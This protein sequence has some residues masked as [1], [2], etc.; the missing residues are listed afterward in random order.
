MTE[1]NRI[2]FSMMNLSIAPMVL[3]FEA[4][5]RL[6]EQNFAQFSPDG[7][8]TCVIDQHHTGAKTP[9]P[10]VTPEDM[11]VDEL[12][13]PASHC[14]SPRE[15]AEHMIW[16]LEN[17]HACEPCFHY[18]RIVWESAERIEKAMVELKQLR[19]DLD[20]EILDPY[21]YFAMHRRF[22]QNAKP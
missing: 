3:D 7:F 9:Q 14:S 12:Y 16:A 8:A 15:T 11:I 2:F 6:T 19:P 20:F 1:H 10:Y 4:P 17:D 18:I 5:N 13:V 21:T 22:L